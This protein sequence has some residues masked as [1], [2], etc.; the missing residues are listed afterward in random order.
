MQSCECWV[1]DSMI[2]KDEKLKMF[3]SMERLILTSPLSKNMTFRTNI[4]YAE[5][6]C[7]NAVLPDQ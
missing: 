3:D 1:V 4:S 2:M 6:D 5:A 7:L